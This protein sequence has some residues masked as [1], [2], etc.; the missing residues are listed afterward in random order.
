MHTA[1]HEPSGTE[2]M[3]EAMADARSL[4]EALVTER[5]VSPP[6]QRRT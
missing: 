2:D 6:L 4:F 1:A 5:P 3:R